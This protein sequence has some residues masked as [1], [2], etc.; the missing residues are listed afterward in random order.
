MAEG[1]MKTTT[2]DAPPGAKSPDIEAYQQAI[3]TGPAS[4][5]RFVVLVGL[6]PQGPI[7][8]VR[9]TR[10]GLAFR[11]VERFQKNTGLSTSDLAEVVDIK[12]RTLHRRKEQGRLE[13][14][15]SDRLL[16]IARIFGKAL[17]LFEGDAD[18]ARQWLSTAQAALG[19]EKPLALAKTDL[20]AREVEALVDRLEHGVLT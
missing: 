17:E 8:M 2:L 19:G 10:K 7:K 14:G 4:A 16:R 11:T 13:P 6:A 3:K 9:R 15:E 1:P 18:A 20:G 5:D 12:M